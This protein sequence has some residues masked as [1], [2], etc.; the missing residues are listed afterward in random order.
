MAI[1][2]ELRDVVGMYL[3]PRQRQTY[4]QRLQ[5]AREDTRKRRRNKTRCAWQASEP[6]RPPGK[7][8]ILKMGSDLKRLM[9][10]AWE[11]EK[12]AKC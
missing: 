5:Q 4:W 2:A 11:K 6:H 10:Q 3:G 9:E 7:P 12:L 1:R 8:T